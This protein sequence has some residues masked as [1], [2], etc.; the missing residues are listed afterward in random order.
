MDREEETNIRVSAT[1]NKNKVRQKQKNL[2]NVSSILITRSSDVASGIGSTTLNDGLTFSNVYGTR[3]QDKEISLNKPDVLRVLGVFESDDQNDPNL[4]T[5]TLINHGPAQT[6]SD[7]VVGEKITG[8]NSRAV[9]RI[10][11]A[12]NGTTIEV[13]YL[14]EKTFT[15]DEQIVGSRPE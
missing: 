5:V 13:V 12:V 6:T 14:N 4:P 10:V 3:V 15:L 1:L 2:N 8:G 9:A 7:L 11:S